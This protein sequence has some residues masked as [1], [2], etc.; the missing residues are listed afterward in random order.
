VFE[1]FRPQLAGRRVVVVGRYPGLHEWARRHDLRMDV[2]EREPRRGR[3]AGPGVEF[4][5]PG[6]TGSS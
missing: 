6:L 4:L 5:L 2:L 1:H 3:L